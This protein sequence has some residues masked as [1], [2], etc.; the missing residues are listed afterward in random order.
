MADEYIRREDALKALGECTYF[1][2]SRISQNTPE[3][4]INSSQ[5]KG[6][7]LRLPAADVAPVVRCKD[8]RFYE[9]KQSKL[10]DMH[11]TAML[12]DDYCSYGVQKE[13]P[14]E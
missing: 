1:D 8:C 13:K 7:L 5:I 4:L 2:G 14:H 6:K 3:M 12:E 10:C 9:V 11:H